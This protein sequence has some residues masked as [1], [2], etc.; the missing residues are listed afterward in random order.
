MLITDRDINAHLRIQSTIL[1]MIAL[2]GDTDEILARLCVLVQELIPS[3]VASLM[4]I[5]KSTGRLMM[6]SAPGIP[7]GMPLEIAPQYGEPW[8][9]AYDKSTGEVLW[10]MQLPAGTTGAPMT[11]M[12]EGRQYIV[13]AVTGRGV[14]AEFV[15][16]SLRER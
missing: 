11:Y 15:A 1:E 16:L 8:F 10:E 13:V 12:H 4:L 7:E 14:P 6:R 2:C 9:R 3:S 5:D